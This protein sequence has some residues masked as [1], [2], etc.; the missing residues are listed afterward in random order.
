MLLLSDNNDFYSDNSTHDF[1]LMTD[2]GTR[3]LHILE[4][5]KTDIAILVG[6]P[7]QNWNLTRAVVDPISCHLCL[8]TGYPNDTVTFLKKSDLLVSI[9]VAARSLAWVWGHSLAGIAGSIPAGH[10]NVCLL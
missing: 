9:P 5:R 10:K 1:S 3:Q 7:K 4:V 6:T 8:S 2:C